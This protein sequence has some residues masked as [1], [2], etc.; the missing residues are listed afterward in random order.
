MPKTRP[1]TSQAVIFARLFE[2]HNGNLSH[3]VARQILQLTFSEQDQARMEELAQR[4]QQG[5]LTAQEHEELTNYVKVG[6]LLAHLHS[7]A[8]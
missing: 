8:R 3:L 6:D 2:G 4:N 5:G 7:K 1:E